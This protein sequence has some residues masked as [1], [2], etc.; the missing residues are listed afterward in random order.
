MP[1]KNNPGCACCGVCCSCF[2]FDCQGSH[3]YETD[4]NTPA[5]PLLHEVISGD[6]FYT[7]GGIL[8]D[9]Q[10]SDAVTSQDAGAIVKPILNQDTVAFEPFGYE[11]G[12]FIQFRTFGYGEGSYRLYF[13]WEDEDNHWYVECNRNSVENRGNFLTLTLVKV[14]SGSDETLAIKRDN[15]ISG[16]YPNGYTETIMIRFGPNQYGEDCL[17]INHHGNNNHC[18]E[19][20]APTIWNAYGSEEGYLGEALIVYPFE[21]DELTS[22]DWAYGNGSV[23]WDE[24]YY[25]EFGIYG[26]PETTYDHVQSVTRAGTIGAG[27]TCEHTH[28]WSNSSSDFTSSGSWS[29]GSTITGSGQTIHDKGVT[30]IQGQESHDFYTI[31]ATIDPNGIDGNEARIFLNYVDDDNYLVAKFQFDKTPI[32]PQPPGSPPYVPPWPPDPVE[33]TITFGIYEVVGGVETSAGAGGTIDNH[34]NAYSGLKPRTFWVL[35]NQKAELNTAGEC[36]SQY[37]GIWVDRVHDHWLD[38]FYDLDM[39]DIDTEGYAVDGYY[40]NYTPTTDLEDTPHKFGFGGSSTVSFSDIEIKKE[41]M[42]CYCTE[43]WCVMFRDSLISDYNNDTPNV[44]PDYEEV[45]GSWTQEYDWVSGTSNGAKTTDADAIML[46]NTRLPIAT[47]NYTVR[48]HFKEFT[49]DNSYRV[50]MGYDDSDNYIYAELDNVSGNAA[51]LSIGTN[52]GVIETVDLEV[53]FNTTGLLNYNPDIVLGMQDDDVVSAWFTSTFTGS[54][55]DPIITTAVSSDNVTYTG[56]GRLSRFGFGTGSNMDTNVEVHSMS[57][58]RSR[59]SDTSEPANDCLTI[60]SQCYTCKPG[61]TPERFILTIS[62]VA[63]QS[64]STCADCPSINGTY[65]IDDWLGPAAQCSWTYNFGDVCQMRL[66]DCDFA[67]G[68]FSVTFEGYN[69]GNWWAEAVATKTLTTTANEENDWDYFANDCFT[70]LNG[71]VLDFDGG[72]GFACDWS[73]ATVTITAL[74]ES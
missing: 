65:S 11:K 59:D 58:Q 45:A 28:G 74:G 51:T 48:V 43:S 33:G 31:K 30:F 70:E 2:L 21:Q 25:D 42:H 32:P 9:Y 67:N 17:H 69:G 53:T 24:D 3:N 5:D 14:V 22:G 68:S 27:W 35:F 40:T 54:N 12:I 34:S 15:R 50:Y 4:S 62:G 38:N 66:L 19:N 49:P 73:S 20:Q 10:N 41:P 55:I 56:G 64:P 13:N 72:S 44:F 6:W 7:I 39:D 16:S 36:A 61:T 18:D 63:D 52:T 37:C 23:I 26:P 71:E 8:V 29:H 57:V 46:S 1:K 60:A 47:N